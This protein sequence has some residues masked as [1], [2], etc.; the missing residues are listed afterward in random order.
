MKKLSNSSANRK[1]YKSHPNRRTKSRAHAIA[2]RFDGS[3]RS[4][5]VDG[6]ELI[7]NI[8]YCTQDSFALCFVSYPLPL[9]TVPQR[10]EFA[11]MQCVKKEIIWDIW[12]RPVLDLPADDVEERSNLNWRQSFPCVQ[13]IF[14][15]LMIL[16]LYL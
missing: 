14:E 12:I 10:L 2:R 15:F 8:N 16:K 1:C 7:I 11:Q 5:W 9:L 13:H 6:I 3:D 4:Q